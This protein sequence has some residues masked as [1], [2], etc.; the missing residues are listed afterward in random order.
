MTE[1][2]IVRLV[3]AKGFGFLR[4]GDVEYFFHRSAVE[5]SSFDLL[6]E[7]TP[8]RFEEESSPRGPRA[9]KVHVA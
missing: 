4:A 7:G 3:V 1:G 2:T 9:G 5:G 8:I 6:R